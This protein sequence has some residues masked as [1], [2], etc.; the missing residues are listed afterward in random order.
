[1]DNKCVISTSGFGDG[2]YPLFEAKDSDGN[3]VG[4]RIEFIGEK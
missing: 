1:M 2:E 4:L 3:V